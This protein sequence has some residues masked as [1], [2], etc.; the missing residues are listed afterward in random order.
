MRD[1]KAGGLE[2]AKLLLAKGADVNAAGTARHDHDCTPL[3][4][5]TVAVLRG[6]AGGRGLHS[7]TFW[8]NISAFRG[9]GGALRD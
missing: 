8:L 4:L 6:E 1:G 9:I 3:G 5:A 7:S 2:L